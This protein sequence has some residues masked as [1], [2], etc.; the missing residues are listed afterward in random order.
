M[1]V[2]FGALKCMCHHTDLLANVF[3]FHNL[4]KGDNSCNQTWILIN[5]PCPSILFSSSCLFL[6]LVNLFKIIIWVQY[7][8]KTQYPSI[9][10]QIP[11]PA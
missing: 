3:F 10:D 8:N 2:I 5:R 7:I 6:L 1:F 11:E 4:T 9:I